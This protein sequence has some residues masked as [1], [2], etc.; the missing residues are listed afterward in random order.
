MGGERW[1]GCSTLRS[2]GSSDELS[3]HRRGCTWWGWK[4]NRLSPVTRCHSEGTW[5]HCHSRATSQ[6]WAEDTVLRVRRGAGPTTPSR[7]KIRAELGP[8]CPE[9][10]SV[11]VELMWHLERK[12]GRS[13][14]KSA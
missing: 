2:W 11:D 14:V 13:M 9:T 7:L 5:W 4:G 1:A 6:L 8:P 3:V 12:D 10:S